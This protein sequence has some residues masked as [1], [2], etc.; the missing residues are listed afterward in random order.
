MNGREIS[1]ILAFCT[2]DRNSSGR[3]VNYPN[4]TRIKYII[5]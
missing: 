4:F 1:Y 2:K 5:D 3:P